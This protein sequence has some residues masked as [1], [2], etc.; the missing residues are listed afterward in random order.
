M[1]APDGIRATNFGLFAHHPGRPISQENMNDIAGRR[2]NF[3]SIH[4]WEG[5]K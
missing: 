1:T 3:A 4:Y 2:N 5:L